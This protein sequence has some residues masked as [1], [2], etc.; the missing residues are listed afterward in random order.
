VSGRDNKLL[1]T[2][3]EM[4]TFTMPSR[5]SDKP[6]PISSLSRP[7]CGPSSHLICS[8][9][10]SSSS[11]NRSSESYTF[12]STLACTPGLPTVPYERRIGECSQ[13]SS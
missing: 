2:T 3:D 4:L 5:N 9:S 7:R 12:F 11:S 1:A 13:E 10:S 6:N 8:S